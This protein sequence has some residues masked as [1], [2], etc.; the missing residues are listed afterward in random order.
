MTDKLA[1]AQNFLKTGQPRAAVQQLRP[2]LAE[3]PDLIAAQLLLAEAFLL[4]GQYPVAA[5][6]L[7]QNHDAVAL[8]TLA[9]RIELAQ[10][11]ARGAALW[12]TGAFAAG[13]KLYAEIHTREA[14]LRA[15]YQPLLTADPAN[16]ALWN[17]L[18]DVAG[19]YRLSAALA[20]ALPD[21]AS[22][23]RAYLAAVTGD[24]DHLTQNC[25]RVTAT[26]FHLPGAWPDA[27]Q[28]CASITPPARNYQPSRFGA[29]K[30]N[31]QPSALLPR[32]TLLLRDALAYSSGD[33][34]FVGGADGHAP[35]LQGGMWGPHLKRHLG[36]VLPPPYSVLEGEGLGHAVATL[37][38]PTQTI[39][40]PVAVLGYWNN[41]GHVLHDV[42]PQLEDAEAVLGR[43]FFILAA[44][45][46]LPTV[47]EAFSA[48]GYP[49]ERFITIPAGS[50]ATVHTAYCFS[51]RSQHQRLRLFNLG[52]EPAHR[53]YDGALDEGGLDFVK[54]RL[55]QRSAS[56]WR[57]IY[58]SRR[59]TGRAPENETA[60][61][62]MMTEA[63]FTVIQPET[64]SFAEQRQL[65]AETRVLVGLEGAG[66]ANM[67]FMPRGGTVLALRSLAWG[68]TVNCFDELA[69]CGGHQLVVM[70]FAGRQVAT[71]AL[72]IAL[73]QLG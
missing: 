64:L 53:H 4:L 62:T 26:T 40:Q 5:Q 33:Y 54:G 68:W 6:T 23:T 51:P 34:L 17:L 28:I 19:N 55:Q 30:S 37:P 10:K 52:D 11:R 22:L 7:P 45:G 27:A 72:K 41:Y 14:E 32:H 42:L 15:H 24:G 59:G 8:Q 49:P 21:A 3:Q 58:L 25:R 43:D 57:K 66:L 61:E 20:G 16:D 29:E 70:D 18:V 46:L 39:E 48:M 35:W 36:F 56:A 73:R 44:G 9:A 12:Q 71:E 31:L 65:F 38:K 63:G 13:K 67:L 1:Q 50:S 2:V 47:Q 69:R 60:L